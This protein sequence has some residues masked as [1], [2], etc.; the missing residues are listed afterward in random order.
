MPRSSARSRSSRSRRTTTPLPGGTSLDVTITSPSDGP[1]RWRRSRDR[2][3]AVGT[4]RRCEHDAVSSSTS[5]AA[6]RVRRRP[7]KCPRQNVYDLTAD[8]TLDC[9]LLAIRDLNTARSPRAPSRGSAGRV[10]RHQ[11]RL[12]PA[13]TSRRRQRSTSSVRGV[14]SLVAPGANTFT[15]PPGMATV[16][17]PHMNL[18]G[19]SSR[20]ISTRASSR[21]RP[22]GRRGPLDGFSCSGR[23][24]SVGD[25]LHRR[26]RRLSPACA[27][28][29]ARTSSSLPLDGIPNDGRRAGVHERPERVAD[30]GSDH[31]HVRVGVG[32]RHRAPSH[33]RLAR[34]DRRALRQALPGSHRRV[35]AVDL[36]PGVVASKLSS[37]TV[38]VDGGRPLQRRPRRRSRCTGPASTSWTRRYRARR[39]TTSAHR[40]QRRG[41]SGSSRLC[42]RHGQ[43]SADRHVGDGSGNAGTTDEGLRSRSP[44]R[45]RRTTTWR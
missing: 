42:R 30:L 31:R 7:G 39:R 1:C 25:E 8:T 27:V 20:H 2:N 5:P 26:A 40:E 18:A 29:P 13:R 44:H 16:F 41:G 35:R 38:S 24:T 22:A 4:G 17:T 45:E 32:V 12:V 43:G 3:A 33:V 37:V 28:R 36:V 10:R 19:S 9:E 21:L 11:R 15:P 6:R 23:T 34:A 14:A